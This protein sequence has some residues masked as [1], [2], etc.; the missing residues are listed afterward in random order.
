MWYFKIKLF[1]HIDDTWENIQSVHQTV[2]PETNIILNHNAKAEF[3][4]CHSAVFV[5]RKTDLL[6]MEHGEY[7]PEVC[8]GYR[9]NSK[10]HEGEGRSHSHHY[11]IWGSSISPL[12]INPAFSV[13]AKTLSLEKIK[14][15]CLGFSLQSCSVSKGFVPPLLSV[16]GFSR[17][18]AY[19]LLSLIS[20]GPLCRY[21]EAVMF[22]LHQSLRRF[23]CMFPKGRDCVGSLLIPGITRLLRV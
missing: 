11:T 7:F 21:C 6:S 4:K 14:H 20:H 5:I 15:S 16:P 23:L 18:C 2:I 3:F 1:W 10:P 13:S 22:P 8:E 17:L 12:K 19:R 9:E